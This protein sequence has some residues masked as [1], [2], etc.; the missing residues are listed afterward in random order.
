ML[1]H[2]SLLAPHPGHSRTGVDGI[3]VQAAREGARLRLVYELSGDTSAITLPSVP[4]C[5]R[6][7]ELW[8]HTCFEAF[9][10]GEGIDGYVEFNFAPNG[11]WA[12]YEFDGY[13]AGMRDLD[14]PAP[15]IETTLRSD[16][17]TVTVETPALPAA[18]ETGQVWLGP[19][20]IVE[21]TA[22]SRSYWALHHPED[23]PD[24]HHAENFKMRLD[25]T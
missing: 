16:G 24:F 4:G 2:T 1:A 10:R 3:T 14:C 18:F 17:L 8:K 6:R 21:D 15:Q 25:E 13:R 12:A 9:V 20:A 23:A 19:S 11:D 22:G 5:A 7:D